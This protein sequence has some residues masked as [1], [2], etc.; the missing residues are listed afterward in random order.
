LGLEI[1]RILDFQLRISLPV[2]TTQ[3]RSSNG[4]SGSDDCPA[5]P[6]DLTVREGCTKRLRETRP[7]SAVAI[8]W[9]AKIVRIFSDIGDCPVRPQ[10]LAVREGQTK[11]LREPDQKAQSPSCGTPSESPRFLSTQIFGMNDLNN[12]H[13]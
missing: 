2:A 11:R 9:H 4:F 12:I 6:E 5:W 13:K 1:D 7:K 8:V 3:S 10:Y